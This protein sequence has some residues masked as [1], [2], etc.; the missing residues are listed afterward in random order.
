MG[1]FYQRTGHN[2][3]MMLIWF[4]RWVA[5]KVVFTFHVMSMTWDTV[6]T[7]HKLSLL[8]VLLCLPVQ[9]FCSR[10]ENTIRMLNRRL[11]NNALSIAFLERTKLTLIAL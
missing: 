5:F 6:L 10:Q 4:S 3:D 2:V 1:Q 7:E 11:F 8:M 9:R